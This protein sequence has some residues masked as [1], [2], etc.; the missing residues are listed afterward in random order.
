M[1]NAIVIA[2]DLIVKYDC[3]EIDLFNCY[4]MTFFIIDAVVINCRFDRLIAI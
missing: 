2:A 3:E 4:H 1:N